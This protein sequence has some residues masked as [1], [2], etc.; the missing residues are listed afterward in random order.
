MYNFSKHEPSFNSAIDFCANL[1]W[2]AREHNEPIKALHLKP[3]FYEW[4]KSGVQT[5]IGRPLEDELMEFDSVNIE[6][7]SL[8]QTKNVV[9]EYYP[10][11]VISE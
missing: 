9:I 2:C 6:K 10:K 1:I 4:Y 7:A 8:F 3:Y 11:N 5:L